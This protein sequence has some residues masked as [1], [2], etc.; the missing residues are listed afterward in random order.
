[1]SWFPGLLTK[2]WKLKLA[3]LS[4]AILLWTSLRVEAIDRQVLPSV[5]VRVQLNDPQWA[6]RTEPVP[7]TVEVQFSGPAGELLGL[8]LDRP[9]VTVPV[10]AVSAADSSV[11]LRS[12]W[13]RLPNRPTVTVEEIRPRR[14]AL[15]FEPINQAVVPV[16]LRTSGFLSGQVALTEPLSVDP[17]VV[18]ISGPASQLEGVDSVTLLP[19]SLP[20]ILATGSRVLP[21]DTTGLYGLVIS[22]GRVRVDYT[23]DERVRRIVDDVPIVPPQGEAGIQVDP[24]TTAVTVVGAHALVDGLSSRSIWAEIPAGQLAGL[25]E[26]EERTVSVEVRGTPALVGAEADVEEVTVRRLQP[27]SVP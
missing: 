14:I 12:E 8:Y 17:E 27:P 4:L 1:M 21:V 19:L 5:P 15:G 23:V 10:D 24:I 3:A 7:A 25:E 6:V 13:V 20:D 2:N 18:R 26:G 11:L 16:A 9:T 22:P